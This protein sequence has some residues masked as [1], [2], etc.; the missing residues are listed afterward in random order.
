M[1]IFLGHF[2][3]SSEERSSICSWHLHNT[4]TYTK[5]IHMVEQQH[6]ET[7]FLLVSKPSL[8]HLVRKFEGELIVCWIIIF[9][10]RAGY[11]LKYKPSSHYSVCSFFCSSSVASLGH[12]E[13]CFCPHILKFNHKKIYQI[14]FKFYWGYWR[15]FKQAEWHEF[16]AQD[17]VIHHTRGNTVLDTVLLVRA[18][19]QKQTL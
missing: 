7:L 14:S 5:I 16:L 17:C 10:I 1:H 11:S 3:I 4:A 9:K 13:C 2:S 6:I 8:Y 19:A 12:L 18:Q 15:H